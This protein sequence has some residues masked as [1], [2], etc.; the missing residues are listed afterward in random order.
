MK[1]SPAWR[2]TYSSRDVKYIFVWWLLSFLRLLRLNVSV[3][4]MRPSSSSILYR[5][6]AGKAAQTTLAVNS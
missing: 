5:C 2:S 6:C 1:P 4:T 3:R